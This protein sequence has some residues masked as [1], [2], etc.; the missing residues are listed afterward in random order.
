MVYPLIEE[1]KKMDLKFRRWSE[2]ICRH[3]GTKNYSIGVLH[4]KM[5]MKIR[6]WRWKDLLK[7]NKYFSIYN[8]NRSW[9]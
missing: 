6:N 9:R 8:C 7:A 5:K 4:G 3:F 2:S 1:S